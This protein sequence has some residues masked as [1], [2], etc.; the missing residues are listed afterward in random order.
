MWR[1]RSYLVAD[2]DT[3]SAVWEKA[4]ADIEIAQGKAMADAAVAEGVDLLIWSSLPNVTKMTE[5][6]LTGVKHFDS[7]ATVETYIR[8]LPIKSAFYMPAFYM[9]NMTSMFKPKKV[10]LPLSV[11]NQLRPNGSGNGRILTAFSPS[12]CLGTK[13]PFSH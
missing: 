9:Q 11:F 12:P 3:E 7:K 10:R 2:E 4:S 6:K 13:M 1:S 5:G 8:G